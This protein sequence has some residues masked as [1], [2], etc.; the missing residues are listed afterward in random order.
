MEQHR[1]GDWRVPWSRPLQAWAPRRA[2][3]PIRTRRGSATHRH[4]SRRVR[5]RRGRR[6]RARFRHAA[7]RGAGDRQIDPAYPGLRRARPRRRACNL[8]IRRGSARAGA[9]SSAAP[10][11]RG[12]ADRP[13]LRHRGRGHSRN[14]LRGS[15]SRAHHHRTRSKPCRANWS[16]RR[17]AR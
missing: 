7:R 2:G 16:I 11:P 3:R 9:A 8:Y 17:L 12:C 13:R 10:G 4:G 6:F 15:A 1:A 14:L 5:P